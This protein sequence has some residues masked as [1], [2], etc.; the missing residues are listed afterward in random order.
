MHSAVRSSPHPG[1]IGNPDAG[2]R[3]TSWG[4]PGSGVRSP[5]SLRLREI[6]S[7]LFRKTCF[8][9]SETDFD[10]PETGFDFFIMFPEQRGR[11]ADLPPRFME[12]VR[13]P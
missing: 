10:L 13:S 4:S 7:P 1:E 8:D 5:E 9:L 12:L 6:F 3:K 2:E 11:T